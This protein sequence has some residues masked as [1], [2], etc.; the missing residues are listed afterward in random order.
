MLFDRSALLAFVRTWGERSMMQH[1]P[2][3][4]QVE[5][6][7]RLIE[8]NLGVQTCCHRHLGLS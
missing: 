3:T 5:S 2:W 4:D 6:C 1:A 8:S 7:F